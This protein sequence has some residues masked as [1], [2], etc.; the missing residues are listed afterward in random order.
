MKQFVTSVKYS[1]EIFPRKKKFLKKEIVLGVVAYTCKV[2]SQ[3]WRQ[4]DCYGYEASMTYTVSSRY[5]KTT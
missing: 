5:R 3:E 1:F 2:F 4:E